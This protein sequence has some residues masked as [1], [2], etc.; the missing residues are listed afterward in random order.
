M[1]EGL[2]IGRI[3]RVELRVV[4]LPLAVPFVSAAELG[5]HAMS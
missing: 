5:P 2:D 1:V 3:E 4:G